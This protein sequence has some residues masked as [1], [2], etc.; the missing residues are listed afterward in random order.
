MKRS[1]ARDLGVPFDGEPGPLN[2][3]TDVPGVEVGHA[4][5]EPASGYPEAHR[6]WVR[7]GVTAIIPRGRADRRPAFAGWSSL[8]GCGELTGV[9]WLEESGFLDTP[10]LSTNTLSVGVVHQAVVEFARDH[11]SPP[12]RWS[13]PVVGE[14]WD[15]FLNDI[16]GSHVQKRHV[17]EAL[18]AA[19]PGL[20]P[21]GNVG[22]GTGMICYELK[23]G[24]G[25]AS[26]T[27]AGRERSTVGVMVQANHGERSQLRIAGVP[28]GREL[29]VPAIRWKD[30]GSILVFVA[31][32][33]P[34]LPHQL[35]RLARRCALGLARTGS[36][37][38]NG[39]GDL[40]LAFSTANPDA[41]GSEATR[42]VKMLPHADLNPLFEAVVQAT[43]EAVVNALI[44]AETMVGYRD[45]R[46]ESLPHEQLVDI[47]QKHRTG[48]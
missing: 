41:A 39:S 20:P 19:R 26:R 10:I 28:V 3:I 12:E 45:H 29:A 42:D 21:E 18:E 43:D 48:R 46:V 17:I 37:S 13:L 36:V 14:T 38:E 4:V 40:F 44:A 30:S 22:G 8:N 35:K 16:W 33:A 31:T 7:T 15:G 27:V 25:T 32:D 47:L 34:V 11:V 6:H 24:I 23:G 9:T 5:V 1:R 2:A